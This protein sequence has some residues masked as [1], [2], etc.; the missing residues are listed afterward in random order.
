MA[1][2]DIKYFVVNGLDSFRYDN[3]KKFIDMRVG[4]D[5]AMHVGHKGGHCMCHASNSH[6]FP[7]NPGTF[8]VNFYPCIY[9][10]GK[11]ES[12][13]DVEVVAPYTDSVEFTIGNQAKSSY[14]RKSL[15]VG[16]R[17]ATDLKKEVDYASERQLEGNFDFVETE[18]SDMIKVLGICLPTYVSKVFAIQEYPKL[19]DYVTYNDI[20]CLFNDSSETTSTFIS[21]EA[22]NRLSDY[23]LNSNYKYHT[24]LCS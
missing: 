3:V 11:V 17:L 6:Q 2:K 23:S 19:P 18:V 20:S 7:I 24:L 8:L 13:E 4:H 22:G 14:K 12:V 5:I 9:V 16:I 21:D 1:N 10:C 15:L